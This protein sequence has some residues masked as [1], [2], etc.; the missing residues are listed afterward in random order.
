MLQQVPHL[1][2]IPLGNGPG[3]VIDDGQHRAGIEL[4][5]V[6]RQGDPDAE[7][8]QYIGKLLLQIVGLDPIR[9]LAQQVQLVHL[10]HLAIG[11]ILQGIDQYDLSLHVLDNL[12]QKGEA[13]AFAE[14]GFVGGKELL[15][16]GG[17][18]LA[19]AQACFAVRFQQRQQQ[20]GLLNGVQRQG[21]EQA[22]VELKIERDQ[23]IE[24]LAQGVSHG[25][26]PN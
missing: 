3:Q 18:I 4:G 25:Q 7:F 24:S 23:L 13:L 2:G 19:L 26:C 10:V 9:E 1:G 5:R 11:R 12:E 16:D 14:V 22:V 15:D 20:S 8:F 21:E 6:R 17:R